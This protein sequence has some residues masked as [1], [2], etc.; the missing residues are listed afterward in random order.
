MLI[1][2]LDG[3]RPTWSA[4]R[5]GAD[6]ADQP[7][8][9]LPRFRAC[10]ARRPSVPSG[11][12]GPGRRLTP[13]LV[14]PRAGGTAATLRRP[15]SAAVD[16]PEPCVL[17]R[18]RASTAR[19]VRTGMRSRSTE[20]RGPSAPA[21]PR[22]GRAAGNGS[23]RSARAS[24]AGAGT[25]RLCS[26]LDATASACIGMEPG[27]D[28]WS[29]SVARI[30]RGR[31]RRSG[32]RSGV[33]AHPV[34]EGPARRCDPPPGGACP[35]RAGFSGTVAPA[36]SAGRRGMWARGPDGSGRS[37]VGDPGCRGTRATALRRT[38]GHRPRTRPR[39]RPAPATACPRL[40]RP[41][42]RRPFRRRS[43]HHRRRLPG[44]TGERQHCR[45]VGLSLGIRRD[46]A[47][48]LDRRRAGVVRGQGV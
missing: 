16:G 21:A 11:R 28:V 13:A 3:L 5:S 17:A 6:A 27:R 22:R 4:H 15:R 29:A 43:C 24:P 25:P 32:R 23:V 39:P 26:D 45:H 30:R 34:P 35:A 40:L 33:P 14:D 9:A 8:P 12:R 7:S 46:P 20:A 38:A 2:R 42:W 19:V 48:A 44:E 10:V 41:R 47:V 31:R 37:G 1:R 36:V 18:R